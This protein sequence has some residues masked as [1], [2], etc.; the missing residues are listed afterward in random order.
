EVA[1][2]GSLETESHIYS[3]ANG[4]RTWER[5]SHV[6]GLFQALRAV[7]WKPELCLLH[8][9]MHEPE[10]AGPTL[11]KLN[12][13]HIRQIIYDALLDPIRDYKAQID[14]SSF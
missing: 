13:P 14:E 1:L 4:A 2:F 3:W 9:V 12:V 8:I 11:T 5:G 10:F 6:S 7:R